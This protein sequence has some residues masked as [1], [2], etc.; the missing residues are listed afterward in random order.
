MLSYDEKDVSSAKRTQ[1]DTPTS[2][3]TSSQPTNVAEVREPADESR[4]RELDDEVPDGGPQA[5]LQ[6]LGSWVIA[7]DTWGVVNSYGVFQTYYGREL[8]ADRSASDLSWVG[9]LQAAL[10]MII[11]PIAGPAYDSGYFR[12]LLWV[13][14]CLILLGQFMTSLCQTF[15]QVLLAQGICIGVG[16]GLVFLPSTAILSQYFKK[17]RAFAIGIASTGSPVASMIFPIIFGRLQP[18]IGFPWATRVLAFLMLG[19]ST[20]PLVF[21]RVRVPPSGKVRSLIDKKAFRD[22]PFLLYCAGAFLCFLTIYVGFFYIQSFAIEFDIASP[23]FSPYLVT[24]LGAGSVLGRIGPNYLADKCGPINILLLSGFASGILCFGWM[25]I[26]NFGGIVAFAVLYGISSGGLVSVTP[27][28]AVSLTPDL[29]VVG[30]RMGM[31]FFSTGIAAV[32]GTPIAGAI[33]GSGTYARWMGAIGYSGAG[34][35]VGSLILVA[36]RLAQ[37]RRTKN[38]RG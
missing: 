21:M 1:G 4:I 33:V 17:R 8:L 28:A 36:C 10:L 26:R 23:E 6:V 24:L 20:I 34:L 22:V 30:T 25:G 16:C 18:T 13:G 35:F 31:Q 5:W 12:H 11:G 29:S 37:H 3:S 14:L 19:L 7:V 27:T 2:T 38:W 9:S 15:W 32:I